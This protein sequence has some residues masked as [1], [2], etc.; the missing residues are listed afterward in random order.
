MKAV[1][2]E[3]R[4]IQFVCRHNSVCE[5]WTGNSTT[6]FGSIVVTSSVSDGPAVP[7]HDHTKH[8]TIVSHSTYSLWQLITCMSTLHG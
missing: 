7:T 6:K 3:I 5:K 4:T 1:L 8:A 2:F